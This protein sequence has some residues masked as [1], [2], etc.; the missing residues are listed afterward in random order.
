MITVSRVQQIYFTVSLPFI[1]KVPFSNGSHR[2]VTEGIIY[3][4]LQNNHQL[5]V[6]HLSTQQLL[7]S[8]NSGLLFN[9]NFHI[10]SEICIF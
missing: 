9:F 8:A 4:L 6:S 10:V 2:S 3:N 5:L 1:D 7:I